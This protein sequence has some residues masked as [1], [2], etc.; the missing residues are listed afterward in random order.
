MGIR[1]KKKHFCTESNSHVDICRN[2]FP[3]V[4][5]QN[6]SESHHCR[7][8]QQNLLM[9]SISHHARHSEVPIIQHLDNLKTHMRYSKYSI[10]KSSSANL[11]HSSYLH[12][13]QSNFNT[14]SK[15]SLAKSAYKL[16]ASAF[17]FPQDL[18]M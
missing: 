17:H 3:R 16:R 11:L 6:P 18:E 4:E 12:S 8:P 9:S 13:T 5:S 10:V 15:M 14:C 2:D 1:R 7:T